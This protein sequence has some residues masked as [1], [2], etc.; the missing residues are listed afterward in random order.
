MW[1]MPSGPC[2]ALYETNKSARYCWVGQPAKEGELNPGHYG[3]VQLY[4][5]NLVGDLDEPNIPD[6]LWYIGNALDVT[7]KLVRK[8]I[9]RGPIFNRRG[10]TTPDWDMLQYVPVYVARFVDYRMSDQATYSGAMRPLIERWMTSARERVIKSAEAAGRELKR[11]AREIGEEGGKRLWHEAKKHTSSG[12]II[13][14]DSDV[15]REMD[16]FYRRNEGLE[17]YY[18]PDKRMTG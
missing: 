8:R 10:G 1:P 15:K 13:P 5:S 17:N 4:P 9:D 18:R 3:L 7:G 11:K 14:Y 6:E 2:R 12:A 16:E